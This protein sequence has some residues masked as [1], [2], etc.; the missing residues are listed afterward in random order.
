MLRLVFVF[1]ILV[2]LAGIGLSTR[3]GSLMSAGMWP[4]IL[5][6]VLVTSLSTTA[7]FLVLI[8]R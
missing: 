1:I 8:F 3:I 6:A 4:L 5:G 7:L 2:G